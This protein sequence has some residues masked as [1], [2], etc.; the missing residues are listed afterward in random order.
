MKKYM[1]HR[2]GKFDLEDFMTASRN[3]QDKT[4]YCKIN[5]AIDID[6]V[7][8]GPLFPANEKSKGKVFIFDANIDTLDEF[9]MSAKFDYYEKSGRYVD[10]KEYEKALKETGFLIKYA[11]KLYGVTRSVYT[12]LSKLAG[13]SGVGNKRK[14]Y[15]RILDMVDGVIEDGVYSNEEK[16]ASIT[17][18]KKN[19]SDINGKIVSL[20]SARHKHNPQLVVPLI[21]F[22]LKK[23][24]ISL[25]NW[26]V[27]DD[28]TRCTV[29]KPKEILPGVFPGYSIRISET[30]KCAFT[31]GSIIKL[32]GVETPLCLSEAKRHSS[33]SKEEASLFKQE[34]EH[35][36]NMSIIRE[37]MLNADADL[38][39]FIKKLE[40][41]KRTL[42]SSDTAK[43]IINKV[44]VNDTALCAAYG[45]KR[46]KA[47]CPS[48]SSS[49]LFEVLLDVLQKISKISTNDEDE[50]AL[51]LGNFV[52][53]VVEYAN[54]KCRKEAT[55]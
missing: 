31:I 18:R 15:S 54:K 37:L 12:E 29:L 10:I 53:E 27:C 44:A 32:P 49:V 5:T 11:G 43:E 50:C 22:H 25:D 14:S 19:N 24:G 4:E 46:L 45:K 55:A 17:I 6:F 33:L 8:I 26:C 35:S 41:A 48:T 30:G 9:N 52:N 1:F 38:P 21:C 47:I 23:E 42:I 39:D 28:I 34:N 16:N 3:L 7:L 2:K 13:I 36:V 20:N 51:A 40:E